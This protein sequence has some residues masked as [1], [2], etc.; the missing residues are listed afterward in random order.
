MRDDDTTVYQLW[1][2]A[3]GHAF[4]EEGNDAARGLVGPD[5]RLVWSVRA[6]TWDEAR[7]RMHAF[8]GWP[9]YRPAPPMYGPAEPGRPKR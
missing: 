3:T 4:F 6:R 9:P 7:R 8:L 5:G 2:T 1:H